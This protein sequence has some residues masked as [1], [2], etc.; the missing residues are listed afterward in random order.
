ML[1]AR[2]L[3]RGGGKLGHP[4]AQLRIFRQR[5]LL[6][7]EGSQLRICQLRL[8]LGILAG[9]FRLG[10]AV[11]CGVAIGVVQLGELLLLLGTGVLQR[12]ALGQGLLTLDQ[13]RLAGRDQAGFMMLA[14]ALQLLQLLLC[15]GKRRLLRPR[16]DKALQLLLQSLVISQ[17]VGLLGQKDAA[18]K[19]TPGQACQDLAAGRRL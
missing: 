8:Q 17:R 9:G 13:L 7:R 4:L 14:A 5:G 3:C 2:R 16:R 18:G 10:S 6:L 12:A 11:G 1:L 19:D 15:L